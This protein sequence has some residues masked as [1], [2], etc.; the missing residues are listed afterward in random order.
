MSSPGELKKTA[1]SEAAPKSPS[2]AMSMGLRPKRS[3]M[4]PA[5][6]RSAANASA[7]PSTIHCNCVWVAPVSRASAGSATLRLATAA[8]T[9]ISERDITRST[10]ARWCRSFEKVIRDLMFLAPY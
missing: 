2:P 3:P 6:R 5:G 10:A 9:I 1:A 7:Y 8:T 4:A